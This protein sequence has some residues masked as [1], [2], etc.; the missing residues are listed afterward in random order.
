MGAIMT[1]KSD[2]HETITNQLIAAIESNPGKPALPW[3]RSGGVSIIPANIASAKTYNGINILSLWS[4]AQLRGYDL[5]VWGTYKQWLEA[6]CQV[7]RGEKA[8]PVI[9]YKEFETDADP[10]RPDDDGKRRMLRGSSV[11]NA[12]QVEG[13]QPPEPTASLGP[14]ERLERADRFTLGCGADIRHGGD[15]AYFRSDTDHIQMPDEG[16]FTGTA[17]MTRSE[18]YYATLVHEL[19][20]WSGAKP[21]LDRDMTGRFGSE[22]YAAEELVAEIGAAFLCAELQVTQDL[23]PDHAAY[24]ATWLRLLK[25]D[26]KAIFTAAAKASEAAGWLRSTAS[27]ASRAAA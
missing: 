10:Q 27:S 24:L 16:L 11:F 18:G 13:Y 21:R 7:R 2:L 4:A 8:S 20:H 14:I 17:T 25:S 1:T 22:S 6:G 15:K 3:R 9:F 12:A 23:R 5:P 19:V 26:P